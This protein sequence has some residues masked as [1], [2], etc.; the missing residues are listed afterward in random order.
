M[1]EKERVVVLSEVAWDSAYFNKKAYDTFLKLMKKIPPTGFI[2]DGG[3]T[4]LHKPEILDDCLTY[5]NMDKEE[6]MEKGEEIPNSQQYEVM[7]T[8]QLHIL[9]KELGRLRKTC[10]DAKIV[11]NVRT[12]DLQDTAKEALNELLIRKREGFKTEIT[13]LKKRKAKLKGVPGKEDAYD[14]VVK[15]LRERS[16]EQQLYREK[17]VRPIVQVVT[18][19]FAKYLLTRFGKI[20]EKHDIEMINE[21]KILTFGEL[22]IDYSHSRHDTWTPIKTR[23]QQLMKSLFGKKQK[24]MVVLE[25]GHHG[26]G[27]KQMQKLKTIATESTFQNQSSYDPVIG[28]EHVT[29]VMALPFEDQAEIAKYIKGLK[30]GR[31]SLGKPTNTKAFAAKNRYKNGGVSGLT[32]ITLNDEGVITTE[33]TQYQ[34]FIDGTALDLPPTYRLICGSSDEHIGSPEENHMARDGYHELFRLLIKHGMS[35][36]GASGKAVSAVFLG[37]TGEANS[38]KWQK[39]DYHRTDPPEAL[40]KIITALE[41]FDKRKKNAVYKMAMQLVK[42][43]REG[44]VESMEVIMDRISTYFKKFLALSLT[45]SELQMVHASVC[46]NHTNAVLGDLGFHEHALF[47]SELKSYKI[48]V[49]ESG[50]KYDPVNG[51]A[52]VALGGYQNA[53]TVH[54]DDYGR[55]MDDSFLFGP[56]NLYMQHDPKGGGY[57]GV[58]GAGKNHG[59]DVTLAGHTHNNWLRCY[60]VDENRFSIAYRLP[61]LQGVT[62]T[63]EYYASGEPRTQGACIMCMDKPGEFIEMAIPSHVLAEYGRRKWLEFARDPEKAKQKNEE[64]SLIPNQE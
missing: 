28:K 31:M 20:C 35:F 55:A 18:D 46:G 6:A 48:G 9:D 58:I 47:R 22:T 56:I 3:T 42:Y 41:G 29:V 39:R 5:W 21:D 60:K 14:D 1:E 64:E 32:A 45:H 15:Q 8:T 33:W 24:A 50:K 12:D 10:P 37:D 27:F 23:C 34:N 17:K 40:E 26:H 7:L 25:G 51:P 4:S 53:L 44:N 36:R 19:D 11:Y 63:E 49:L 61:T 52:R 13:G 59:A 43:A 16:L 38:R 30:P 62:P 57:Q 2:V 54:I